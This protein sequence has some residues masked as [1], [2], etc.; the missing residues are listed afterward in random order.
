M[1]P[2]TPEPAPAKAF[3]DTTVPCD[4]L[5]GAP[6]SRSALEEKLRGYGRLATSRF[7]QLEFLLG[8]YGH[9]AKFQARVQRGEPPD[10]LHWQARRWATMPGVRWQKRVGSAMLAA[11]SLFLEKLS[12]GGIMPGPFAAQFR[13]FLRG[14]MRRAWRRAFRGVDDLLDPSGCL[15]DLPR[16]RWNGKTKTMD[17][18]VSTRYV[19]DKAPRLAAFIRRERAQFERILEA[20]VNEESL[21][22]EGETQRRIEAIRKILAGGEEATGGDIR[23]VGDAFVA[24]ECPDDHVLLNNNTKHF[25]PITRAIGKVSERSFDQDDG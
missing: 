19:N 11:F 9:V 10:A 21:E 7:V 8:V 3:L 25:E 17:S 13:G 1:I 5:L 22:G 12:A 2:S 24:V 23:N 14:F 16:P 6:A 20:L 15:R 18:V 4:R